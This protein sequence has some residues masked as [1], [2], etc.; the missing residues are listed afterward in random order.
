M[1]SEIIYDEQDHVGVITLNRP[2]A[3]TASSSSA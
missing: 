3:R 2:E 1:P